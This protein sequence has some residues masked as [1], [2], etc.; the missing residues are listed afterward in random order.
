MKKQHW[1]RLA[2]FAIFP[3]LVAGLFILVVTIQ[4]EF[5]YNQD[6]FTLLYQDRYSS[7]GT[8]AS[9][10]EKAIQTSDQDLYLELTGLRK[11]PTPIKHNP[12]IRLTILLEVDEAGYFQYLFFDVKTYER[13]LFF[14]KNV[15]NRW[16]VVPQDA[17]F[18]LDSGRWLAVF[19]PL[20]LIWWGTLF[21]VELAILVYRTAARFRESLFKGTINH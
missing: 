14:L 18:Y 9:A 12:N 7:P 5:R 21:V 10:L 13:A 2:G 3:L 11:K 19:T 1:F 15:M 20:A 16:I 17:Y 6:F 4:A 8:V